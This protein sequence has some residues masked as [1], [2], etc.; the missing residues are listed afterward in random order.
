MIDHNIIIID[1]Y[2]VFFFVSFQ[3]LYFKVYSIWAL[4][5][6]FL[7]VSLCIKYL[8][9]V[10]EF[11]SVYYSRLCKLKLLI[12]HSGI[13]VPTLLILG[14]RKKDPLLRMKSRS[15][16]S[17]LLNRHSRVSSLFLLSQ[18]FIAFA[19]K[20]LALYPGILILSYWA[21]SLEQL[22]LNYWDTLWN[23]HLASIESMLYLT[24]ETTIEL[25][26]Y[27]QSASTFGLAF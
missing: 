9:S 4:L 20:L 13:F 15:A 26:L 12:L 2:A 24:H 18:C 3:S 22:Y 1:H 23:T 25:L 17:E 11:L 14:S 10:P 27:S 6:N 21:H 8:I 19:L 16:L 7:L 5:L